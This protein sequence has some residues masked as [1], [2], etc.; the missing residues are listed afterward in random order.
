MK[1]FVELCQELDATTSTNAKVDAMKR[2]FAEASDGDAAWALYFLSGKRM[3][4]LAKRNDLK[5][6]LMEVSGYPLWM[7]E[8]CYSSVGDFAETAALLTRCDEED[9]QL[10]ALSLSEWVEQKLIPL[11]DLDSAG[12]EPILK[13]WWTGLPFE[14]RFIATK[15][16]TGGLRVGVSQLLLAK[17]LA[18]VSGLPRATLLHRMMGQ[19]VP[20]A[21]AYRSLVDPE[22]NESDA[23]Q[24]YPF[25]LASP[26][27]GEVADLGPVEDWVAEWK[28]DG[29]RAQVIRREG[30]VFIWSR[31]EELVTER[32]PEI[33]AACERLPEG[34]VL[35]GE[36][37]AWDEEVLP[38]SQ[39]QR[40]LNRKKVSKKLMSEVPVRV[41]C[42][43]CM[44][45]EG[46]DIRELPLLERRALLEGIVEGA[47]V[48][49]L[50]ISPMIRAESWESLAEM[51]G[52]SR[53]RMVEGLM[54]KSAS[55]VYEVGRKRGAWWKWKVDPYTVDAVMIY[56]QAGSGRR[57]N[58][59]TDYTFAV[60]SGDALLPLAK[61][62]SGLDN[63]EIARLDRW[64][65][66]NTIERFG[67]VRSVQPEQVFEIAFEGI[68]ES[69]RNKS[70]VALRFPR[71]LRWRED[72][73]PK[74]ADTLEQ[75]RELL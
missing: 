72:K 19:F 59:F 11:M 44:E 40:R 31:G 17:A 34:T 36:L 25:F 48:R 27:D 10:E 54:L 32:F 24:P 47:E 3:K 69:K 45:A 65:R 42:Y 70:G 74:D 37:L 22:S 38:F 18:L 73:L 39:M 52:E 68:N 23:S 5:Q 71:I 9:V 8:E 7:V 50:A 67:P 15:L 53:E 43:D 33:E 57:A 26:I 49:E 64:I 4:R 12:Q 75:V 2:F 61:A 63:K 16:L 29:I 30:K 60:W 66:A 6:W 28:W 1:A 55:S 20:S 62:Y 51:R 35:D 46:K 14:M 13:A 21:E 41:V 58:L 56:A